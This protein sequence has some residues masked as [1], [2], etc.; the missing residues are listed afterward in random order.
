MIHRSFWITKI[1]VVLDKV[2]QLQNPSEVLKIAADHFN[3]IKV[4]AMGSSTLEVKRKF[5]HTLTGRKHTVHLL[6]SQ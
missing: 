3:Q 1:L 5:S 6:P 4:I 2:H